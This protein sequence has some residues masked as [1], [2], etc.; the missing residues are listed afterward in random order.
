[1]LLPEKV[2]PSVNWTFKEM[3]DFFCL[4]S[5]HIFADPPCKF[6]SII[7]KKIAHFRVIAN[8]PTEETAFENLI[9]VSVGVTSPYWKNLFRDIPMFFLL[10]IYRHSS[11]S[12]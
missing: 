11:V 5:E 12:H 6:K 7:G 3:C 1:M 4:D 9:Y 8:L 10:Q 2:C